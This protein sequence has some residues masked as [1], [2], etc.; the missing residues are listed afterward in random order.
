MMHN[1]CL[2]KNLMC[3]CWNSL[4]VCMSATDERILPFTDSQSD[5]AFDDDSLPRCHG[6]SSQP[7]DKLSLSY[8]RGH[9]FQATPFVQPAD[10]EASPLQDS[11]TEAAAVD[12][13]DGCRG[14]Y[15]N[16]ILDYFEY[17]YQISSKLIV[18]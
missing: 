6:P 7:A 2:D 12:G 13:G 18:L 9:A 10:S 14:E 3:A 5:L 16:S 17:F 1:Y 4:C 15:T 11:S 8:A